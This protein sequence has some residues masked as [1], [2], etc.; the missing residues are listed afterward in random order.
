MNKNTQKHIFQ[1]IAIIL[2]LLGLFWWGRGNTGGTA[3]LPT[4]KQIKS[5]SFLSAQEKSFDFGTISMT[6]GNVQKIFTV[7]NNTDKDIKLD[8]LVTSCM[9][10]TAFLE[11]SGE[12]M[13]PFGMPGHG[14]LVPKVNEII[15]A[16]ESVDAVVVF[17]PTAHGPDGVGFVERYVYFVDS[18][19]GA[20]ELQITANVTR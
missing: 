16:G 10:T 18:S 13:G 12:R 15:K 2:L 4:E 19:G 8:S 7:I 5:G 1:F 3:S 14:G 20:L 9:C 11:M 17:D 6:D